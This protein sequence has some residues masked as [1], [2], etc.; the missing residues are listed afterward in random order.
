MEVCQ[1]KVVQMGVLRE[2]VHREVLV[3]VPCVE[4]LHVKENHGVV[5]RTKVY[6]VVHHVR[7]LLEVVL[8]AQASYVALRVEDLQGLT[9]HVEDQ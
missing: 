1:R 2:E 5:F 4:A 7:D 9:G 8:R 3:N 6:V